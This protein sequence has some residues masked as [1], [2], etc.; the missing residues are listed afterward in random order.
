[1]RT[2]CI[3]VGNPLRGDD[4]VGRRVVE[5]LESGLHVQQLTPEIAEEIGRSDRVIIIDASINPGS[6]HLEPIAPRE[7]R[8]SPLAHAMTPAEAVCLASSLFGFNGE[9]FICHVPGVDFDP[10]ERLSAEAE[11]NAHLAA[12]IVRVLLPSRV[13]T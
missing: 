12:E 2:L 5:L 1:M 8:G 3:A 9:A 7:P 13:L 11:N 6:P 10:G 4:G